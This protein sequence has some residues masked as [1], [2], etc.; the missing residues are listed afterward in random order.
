MRAV[1]TYPPQ[2]FT[3]VIRDLLQ[4][5]VPTFWTEELDLRLLMSLQRINQAPPIELPRQV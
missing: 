1:G 5:C 4:E 2:D 3:F